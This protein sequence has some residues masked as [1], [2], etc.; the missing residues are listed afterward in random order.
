MKT[1]LELNEMILTLTNNIRDN[2]PELLKF[3][4]EKP[5]IIPYDEHASITSETLDLYYN[6]LTNLM[7]QYQ[8]NG[9]E[10]LKLDSILNLTIPEIK[11]MEYENSYQDLLTEVNNFTV[12]YYDVGEGNIPILL[13][14]GYPFDKSMW[15]GQLDVLKS[16]NR[17]IAIDIRGFGKS[18]DEKSI[19]SMD[20]FGQDL[21]ALMDKLKIEKAIICGLSMG[22]FIALNAMG[23]FPNRFEGLILCDTQCVADT[24]EGREKRYATIEQVKTDGINEFAEGFIK[25]VFHPESL[26]NKTEIVESLSSVVYANS[27]EVI[28]AGLSALATRSETC[29]NLSSISIPTLIICGR[30]D[31]VTPLSQSEMMHKQIKNSTLKVIDHAG[32]VS[33]LEQPEEFN[34]HL[35]EFLNQFNSR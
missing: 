26:L 23:K 32:H 21:I 4:N 6:S 33:N 5:V 27:K 17:L 20:L 2:F 34:R 35:S 16:S 19:L 10:S 30:E 12:S 25:N 18:T 24:N 14:H 15:T 11:T 22:G 8:E 7:K 3:L 1:E 29:T 13:L 31:K 28:N 9:L